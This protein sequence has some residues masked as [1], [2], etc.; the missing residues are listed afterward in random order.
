M[1]SF[2]SVGEL[3]QELKYDL[4]KVTQTI[5]SLF[6]SDEE[7][8]LETSAFP[9]SVR[10]SIYFINSVDKPNFRASLP[11]RRSTTVSIETN[12]LYYCKFTLVR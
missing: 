6:R 11:H 5:V 12:P 7:L 2:S 8:T 10:W 3:S 4:P 1:G 9:I